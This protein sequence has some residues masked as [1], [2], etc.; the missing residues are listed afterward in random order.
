MNT[1]G[2]VLARPPPEAGRRVVIAGPPQQSVRR[3]DVLPELADVSQVGVDGAVGCY[4]RFGDAGV[5]IGDF[6]FDG[7]IKPLIDALW[8]ML[9]GEPHRPADHRIRDLRVERGG[10]FEGVEVILWE[11]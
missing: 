9:G 3:N 2:W 1:F 8:P 4:L 7:P 11:H 6:G 10:G 5:P